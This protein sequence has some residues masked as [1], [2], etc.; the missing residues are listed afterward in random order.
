MTPF[1][2]FLFDRAIETAKRWH[3]HGRFCLRLGRHESAW[4]IGCYR[5]FDNARAELRRAR[6][7]KGETHANG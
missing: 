1:E 3:D 6:H 5:A 7:F 2:Q 4:K